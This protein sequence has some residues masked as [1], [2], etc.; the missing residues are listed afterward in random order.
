M[1]GGTGFIG[2]C[3]ARLF[4]EQGARVRVIARR[5]P[6]SP[7]PRIEYLVLDRY[8]A[9]QLA[10][11]VGASDWD[12]V[13][14]NLVYHPAHVRMAV[15]V[16][17]GRV[18]RYVLNSS[19]AVY[20][21][22]KP[23]L[24]LRE[25][26]VDHG[27]QALAPGQSWFAP[28]EVAS[29]EPYVL[30]KLHAERDLIEQDA[31]SYSIVRTPTTVG[32]RDPELDMHFY[33]ERMLDGQPV[34]LVDGGTRRVQLAYVEDVARGIISAGIEPAAAGRIYNIADGFEG[35]LLERLSEAAR[36]IGIGV[37][38][39]AVPG[40]LLRRVGS[41]YVVPLLVRPPSA[42]DLTRARSDLGF[43]PTPHA[44]WIGRA[45]PWYRDQCPSRHSSGYRWCAF[46]THLARRWSDRHPEA[47]TE[48][49][50]YDVI[51]ST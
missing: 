11:A 25:K 6:S 27:A 50:P 24:P 19:A 38:F 1:L 48:I 39:V 45:L 47:V 18:G 20:L 4:A 13:V 16:L 44:Q 28:T 3:V 42:F 10:R 51:G 15:E 22:A 7:D 30:G 43:A 40:R 21:T 36:V 37:R 9:G 46:E 49:S 41:A 17:A 33:F 14:D 26:A 34:L 23:E 2:G 32:P 12:V 35:T 31:L 8:D 29:I 5:P